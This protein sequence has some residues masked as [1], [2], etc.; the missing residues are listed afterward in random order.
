MGKNL[1]MAEVSDFDSPTGKGVV[2][3]VEG[4]KLAL[5]NARFL[6]E[7][8]IDVAPLA[9]QAEARPPVVVVSREERPFDPDER[10]LRFVFEADSWVEVRDRLD[11]VIFY[12]LNAAGTTRRVSGLPPL[13]VV[14]GNAHGVK[15]TYAGQPVDLAR[16]TKVDVARLTLE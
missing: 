13:T 2:G 7:M 14:V 8:G 5:G 9:A 16:H 11:R 15:M 1:P 6:S 3:T 12:Q 10:E 4:R